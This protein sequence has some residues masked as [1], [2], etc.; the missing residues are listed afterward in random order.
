M[1]MSRPCQDPFMPM[2]RPCQDPFM[3]MSRSC[4]DPFMPMSRP[5]LFPYT[6]LSRPSYFPSLACQDTVTFCQDPVKTSSCLCQK[7]IKD[8]VTSL[9]TP[10]QDFTISMSRPCHVTVMSLTR[11]PHVNVKTPSCQC[12]DLVKTLSGSLAAHLTFQ[13]SL[14]EHLHA[15]FSHLPGNASPRLQQLEGL[16]VAQWDPRIDVQ[17]MKVLGPVCFR[18]E[19]VRSV[20]L[21][22]CL[23]DASVAGKLQGRRL[24][25]GAFALAPRAPHVVLF[26]VGGRVV[27]RMSGDHCPLQT[28]HLL[29]ASRLL[30]LKEITAERYIPI[31][32][33]T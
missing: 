3:P 29:S 25:A 19:V 27:T 10:C 24:P 22:L 14:Y 13:Y 11:H 15:C 28:R 33:P 20:V 5:C 1:P 18:L 9:S 2:S 31:L 17:L 32:R 16:L 6:S 8:S 21:H 30:H 26:V 12:Q 4:Q 23:A 7:T